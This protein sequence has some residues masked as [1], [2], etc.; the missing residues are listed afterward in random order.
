MTDDLHAVDVTLYQ[1]EDGAWAEVRLSNGDEAQLIRS[2]VAI[3][4]VV[5]SWETI[6]QL[7]SERVWR[8]EA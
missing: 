5:V 1:D 7:A 2:G 6:V 8:P 3:G 4:D